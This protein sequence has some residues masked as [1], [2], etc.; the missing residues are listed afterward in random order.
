M[1]L[2]PKALDAARKAAAAHIT[3][4]APRWESGAAAAERIV[5]AYVAALDHDPLVDAA[6]EAARGAREDLEQERPAMV[7]AMQAQVNLVE[8][9]AQK[10]RDLT[11]RLDAALGEGGEP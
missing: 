11:R 5:S 10:I 2:D 1:T 6:R 7:A 8:W 4:A 3:G 9:Q